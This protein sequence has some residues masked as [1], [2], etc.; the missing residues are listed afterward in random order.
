LRKC[1]VSPFAYEKYDG[2]IT[3]GRSKSKPKN[4]EF[5]LTLHQKSISKVVENSKISG[6]KGNHVVDTIYSDINFWQPELKYAEL[7]Y[8]I[9]MI[10]KNLSMYGILTFTWLKLQG[11]F[12]YECILLFQFDIMFDF[13][14]LN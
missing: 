1:V 4:F 3:F 8:V 2:C 12:K 9:L 5:S 6:K 14:K 13:E 11:M 10:L 7:T